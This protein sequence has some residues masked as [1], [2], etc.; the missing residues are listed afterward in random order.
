MLRFTEKKISWHGIV[1]L[2]IYTD[3]LCPFITQ[4]NKAQ[5]F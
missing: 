3:S 1:T 4:G 2:N 5:N